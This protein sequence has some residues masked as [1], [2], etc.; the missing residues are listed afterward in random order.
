MTERFV[1]IDVE[2]ANPDMSSI[3]QVGLAV[4]ENG[5]RVAAHSML[6]DPED[7]FDE[8][9]I[10][11]HGITPDQVKGCPS[12]ADALPEIRGVVRDSVLASYGHFDKAAVSQA[13]AA[14][15]VELPSHAWLN[16]HP[17]VRR[18][19]PEEAATHG[20]ALAKTA[21]RLG[22]KLVSHH[23]AKADAIAAGEIFLQAMVV[24]GLGVAEWIKRV[25]MP[26]HPGQGHERHV[27]TYEVNPEGAL[28]GEGIVFTGALSM[29]REQ[30]R[31]AA[32]KLG[33]VPLGGVS[34]KT[35]MLVV[36]DQDIRHLRGSDKSSKHR[37]AEELIKKGHPLRILGESDFMA[38]LTNSESGGL[39][40]E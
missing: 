24:S 40:N 17:V 12:F 23:D 5:E 15:K 22:V 29:T 9:N 2:T 25:A 16:L 11:I 6:I 34:K 4:Y 30:A 20:V 7:D 3:C 27:S 19:W 1:V 38:M 21:K 28:L 14:Y 32:A 37:K 36:G 31:E 39:S 33:C 18:A 8:F 10:A 26:I 35:T 13:C